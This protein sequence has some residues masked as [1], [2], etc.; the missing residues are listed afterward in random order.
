MSASALVA[1]V[2]SAAPALSLDPVPRAA[3]A[4]RWRSAQTPAGPGEH[5]QD[6][7]PSAIRASSLAGHSPAACGMPIRHPRFLCPI[8]L[9]YVARSSVE[10]PSQL[11][12]ARGGRDSGCARMDRSR[13]SET[14]APIARSSSAAARPN[15]CSICAKDIGAKEESPKVIRRIAAGWL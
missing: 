14:D 8:N 12:V 13:R 7:K 3:S 5:A 6:R 10:Y 2:S 11:A 9:S 15:A 1:Q 4:N